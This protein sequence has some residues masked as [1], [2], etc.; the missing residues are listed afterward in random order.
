MLTA[1]TH[2]T[3]AGMLHGL[4]VLSALASL[5]AL[6]L[7]ALS[8]DLDKQV[9]FDIPAQ[10]LSAAL[11]E[12]SMRARLQ[13]IVSDDLTGQTTQGVSGQK[14]IKQALSQLLEPAGLGY[15]VTG[16]TSITVGKASAAA[17]HTTRAGLDTSVLRL[18][19]ND[20][21]RT[22]IGGRSEPPASPRGEAERGV[23]EEVVVTVTRRSENL[24][25]IPVSTAVFTADAIER[26]GLGRAQ[27]LVRQTPGLNVQGPYTSVKPQFSIRGIVNNAV[28][29]NAVSAVGI[30][31]DDIYLNSPI[32]QGVEMFDLE[33]VEILRGPQG[34]LYGANTTGGAIS[35]VS[36][37]PNPGDPW[38]GYIE[39]EGGNHG[40]WSG[41]GAVTIP[42]GDALAA[43]VSASHRENRGYRR[44]TFTGSDQGFFDTDALRAQL[45]WNVSD[46]FRARLS[47]NYTNTDSD[48][49]YEQQ[50]ARDPV[51]F[52]ACSH[53]EVLARRCVD[54][55]G[56]SDA[57][58]NNGFYQGESLID[59]TD[60]V[61]VRGTALTLEWRAPFGDLTSVTG[62]YNNAYQSFEDISMS[63]F[64]NADLQY[65]SSGEQWT[66]EL[67][68]ASNGEGAFSWILGGFFLHE[69][70]NEFE[71]VQGESLASIFGVRSAAFKTYDLTVQDVALFADATYRITPRFALR[72]GVRWTD[73]RKDVEFFSGIALT[74]GVVSQPIGLDFVNANLLFPSVDVDDARSWSEVTAHA[75][76][77]LT[78]A[79]G[80]M[81]YLSFA[82]GFRGGNF[83]ITSLGRGTPVDPEF[84]DTVEVGLKSMWLEKRLRLNASAYYS[85]Y[86]DQQV[87]TVQAP[88]VVL[89]N[90]ASSTIKGLEIEL[91]VIPTEQW[92][93]SAGIGLMRARFDRFIDAG[94]IDR[95]GNRLENTPPVTFN[96][97]GRYEWPILKLGT[98]SV[99]V[100]ASYKDDNFLDFSNSPESRQEAFWLT[101]ARLEYRSP[102]E[103]YQVALW[104]KNLGDERYYVNWFDGVNFTGSNMYSTGEPRTYGATLSVRW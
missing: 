1:R 96:A 46:D 45:A 5:L 16:E 7:V 101:N 35:F 47:F 32:A 4:T 2:K 86:D 74:P 22:E 85:K 65:D 62:F 29:A 48:I 26:L 66:W 14:A 34:T 11:I 82:R 51:S 64:D 40:L 12:F 95:S 71:V 60:H 19:Q 68:L 44:N 33:R 84:V 100:D 31:V 42:L 21:T 92:F 24:Q 79:D 93:L 9:A 56:Y 58:Q 53:A 69:E 81:T 104:G 88:V 77:E 70:S 15:R 43:R 6:P 99:Q 83:D 20:Q 73:E 10:D 18:A 57:A 102:G 94:G 54:F 76:V 17:T 52:A 3:R 23:L 91:Q 78:V 80:V 55:F 28:N 89:A 25:N 87:T 8:A 61:V 49:A 90:A 97:L 37:K 98:L 75:A 27:D 59:S 36:R 39:A 50:G 63:P 41:E 103:R 30:Y 13:V 38:N 67:R 72:G